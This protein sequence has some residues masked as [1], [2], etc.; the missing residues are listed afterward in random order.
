V[1]KSGIVCPGEFRMKRSRFTE[2]EIAQILKEAAA[3]VPLPDLGRV[4]GFSQRSF[5]K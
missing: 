5:C 1:E 2:S 3:G 4:H